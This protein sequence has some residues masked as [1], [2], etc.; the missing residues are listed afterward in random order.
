[1]SLIDPGLAEILVCPA[2]HGELVERE[3]E[4]LLECQVCHRKYPVKGGI[5]VMLLE[6]G[7]EK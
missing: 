7:V 5:P 4:S 1:V 2:D 6:G 3:E